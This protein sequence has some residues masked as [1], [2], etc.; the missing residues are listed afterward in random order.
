MKPKG[1]PLKGIKILDI[2]TMLAAPLAGGILADQ[3]GFKPY[4][5]PPALACGVFTMLNGP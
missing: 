4:P 2:G 1:G 5:K 3:S